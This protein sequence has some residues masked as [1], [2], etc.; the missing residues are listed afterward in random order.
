[1]RPN[2]H[3]NIS[4]Q[5]TIREWMRPS[6]EGS[7][8]MTFHPIYM[9]VVL[10]MMSEILLILIASLPLFTVIL[11]FFKLQKELEK[12]LIKGKRLYSSLLLLFQMQ[13]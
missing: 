12:I 6:F 3:V 1:M 13:Q 7:V 2:L 8:N 4:E 9:S 5:F 10:H 11:D